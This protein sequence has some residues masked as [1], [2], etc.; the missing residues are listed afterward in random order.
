MR[1]CQRKE[2]GS[3]RW[4]EVL[5]VDD[6]FDVVHLVV[7]D[8]YTGS[9]LFLCIK[10]FTSLEGFIVLHASNITGSRYIVGTLW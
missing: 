3:E 5:G 1:L 7:V 4:Y 6:A 10:R 9:S 2:S 8:G